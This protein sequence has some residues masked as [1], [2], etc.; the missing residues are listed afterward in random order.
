MSVKEM[1]MKTSKSTTLG[2]TFAIWDDR[3][4]DCFY[5]RPLT[6]AGSFLRRW[7]VQPRPPSNVP[8]YRKCCC[9]CVIILGRTFVVWLG[10]DF[11]IW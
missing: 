7:H 3:N 8:L 11:W 4:T 10:E 2:Q 5:D 1:K 6:G 9:K